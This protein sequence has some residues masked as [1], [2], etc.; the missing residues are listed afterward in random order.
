MR[1]AAILVLVGLAARSAYGQDI[2]PGQNAA[3]SASA[4]ALPR[5]EF[6]APPLFE[7]KDLQ[8]KALPWYQQ[9]GKGPRDVKSWIFGPNPFSK[10]KLPGANPVWFDGLKKWDLR[11]SVCAVPLLEARIPKEMHFNMP[12]LPAEKIGSMPEAQLP[13]PSCDYQER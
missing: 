2:F 13:A 1:T 5:F 10:S 9:M 6:P 4:P 8:R 7:F 3:P 12:V 11:S